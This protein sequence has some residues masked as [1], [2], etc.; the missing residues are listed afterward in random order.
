MQLQDKIAVV[1]GGAHRVGKA[2][3]LALAQSGAQV[4]VHYGGS[5][6]AAADTVKEIEAL[7]VRAVAVQADLRDPNAHRR[8]VQRD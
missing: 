1:T 3:A 2:I 8:A 5:E 4:V 6:Q 7:G